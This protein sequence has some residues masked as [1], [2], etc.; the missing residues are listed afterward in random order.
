MTPLR[1]SCREISNDVS[2]SSNGLRMRKLWQFEVFGKLGKIC[3][4][5]TWHMTA[6]LHERQV[7]KLEAATWHMPGLLHGRQVYKLEAATCAN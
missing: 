1:R 7:E 2:F 4:S 5:A 3:R 6:L